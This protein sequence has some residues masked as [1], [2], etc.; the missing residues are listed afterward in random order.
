MPMKAVAA[1]VAIADFWSRL[2]AII[3]PFQNL[4][5]SINKIDT[6]GKAKMKIIQ[7]YIK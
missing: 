2:V 3:N 5:K 4:Y 7:D 1:A 6:L